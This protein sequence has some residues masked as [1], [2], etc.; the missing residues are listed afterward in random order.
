MTIAIPMEAVGMA[1]PIDEVL[2]NEE[3]AEGAV[4]E[5]AKETAEGQATTTEVENLPDSDGAVVADAADVD[6]AALQQELADLRRLRDEWSEFD[7]LAS[8]ISQQ[9]EKQAVVVLGCKSAVESAKADLKYESE[10]YDKLVIELRKLHADRDKGQRHLPFEKSASGAVAE[11]TDVNDRMCESVITG[12]LQ[13]PAAPDEHASD[14]IS[15]LGQK[16]MIKLAGQDAWET[17]KNRE[18]PFGMAAGE[19]AILEEN[20]LTTIGKLEKRMREE[21]NWYRDIKKFGEKKV[22]KLI[23]SL[24][25]FRGK[26]PQPGE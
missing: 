11:P 22:A 20:E 4:E 7:A 25:V 17:A 2:A 6:V 16:D 10:E 18:E 1:D 5:S 9:V 21:P 15:V 26:Y 13:L 24:R 19:L 3:M 12:D 23:E 8:E 14:P